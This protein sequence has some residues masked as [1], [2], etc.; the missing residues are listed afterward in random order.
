MRTAG[1]TEH[2]AAEQNPAALVGLDVV[3]PGASRLV[4]SVS[5]HLPQKDDLCGP[6]WAFAAL[7]AAG[8][9]VD[10]PEEVAAHAG[11]VLLTGDVFSGPPGG[12]PRRDY[13]RSLSSTRD[14]AAAGTD[15]S[16]V[17]RALAELGGGHVTSE[18][19]TGPSEQWS[20]GSLARVLD[21]AAAARPARHG[22]ATLAVLANVATEQYLVPADVAAERRYLD[23]GRLDGY[24]PTAWRVGH[25]V[26]VLGWRQ[27]AVGRLYRL[28]DSYPLGRGGRFW[29]DQ[30]AEALAAALRRP[31]RAPGSL[32]VVRA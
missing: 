19:V 27:G 6:L 14:A 13:D 32:V 23:A 29:H 10:S 26:A 7:R 16:G 17:I 20:P 25:F 28:H 30:P 9:R 3:I 2:S 5:G 1:S 11:T 4:A 15:V 22:R 8:R 24:R 18:L 31:G 21:D 12:T